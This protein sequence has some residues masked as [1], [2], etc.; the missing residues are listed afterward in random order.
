MPHAAIGAGRWDAQWMLRMDL[1]NRIFAGHYTLYALLIG[2]RRYKQ[3][4]PC[5]CCKMLFAQGKLDAV[6]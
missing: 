3:C 6:R 2:R 4:F 5:K 1:G